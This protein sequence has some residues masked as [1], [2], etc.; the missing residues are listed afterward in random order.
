[1]ARAQA[2]TAGR[3]FAW[4]DQ[5]QVDQIRSAELDGPTQL[6]D[7]AVAQYVAKLPPLA[8]RSCTGRGRT[9]EI[10]PDGSALPV[11]CAGCHGTGRT[12]DLDQ[13]DLTDHARR[14][15][16]TCWQLGGRRDLEDLQLRQWAHMLGFRGH[17]ATKS[18]TYSTTFGALRQERADFA[19]RNDPLTF[20]NTSGVLVVN[21]WSYA[22]RDDRSVVQSRSSADIRE[23][24]P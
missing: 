1:M 10:L 6:T 17:F 8:C 9:A 7:V 15:I 18:R 24:S 23:A 20:A 14:L 3:V 2:Q 19:G 11:P 12:L 13:W 16:E 21:H 4:G 22:G 5:L